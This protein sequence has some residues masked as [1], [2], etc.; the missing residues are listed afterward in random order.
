MNKIKILIAVVGCTLL[1]NHYAFSQVWVSVDSGW[2]APL[3]YFNVDTLHN[4]LYGTNGYIFTAGGSSP[5]RGCA[6]YDGVK[7]DTIPVLNNYGSALGIQY[8]NKFIFRQGSLFS[9]DGG[10]QVDT[11]AK[12]SLGGGASGL[13]THNGILYAYGEFDSINGIEAHDIAKWDGTTWS[14]IDT[15][16]WYSSGI[17]CATFYNNELYIGGGMTNFGNTI[18]QV[19][20]W[21]GVHWI[22]L[23]NGVRG[24]FTDVY[25]CEVYN[26]ELY[27]GGWFD[28]AGGNPGNA[29]ARWNG[30][31]WN[32]VGGGMAHTNSVIYD[33]QV[34]NNELFA[35]GG[36]LEAGG[37]T[38]SLIGKWDGSNWCSVGFNSEAASSLRV[39]A[40]Y[41]NELYI[42]GSFI[43]INGDTMHNVAKWN[44]GN[45]VGNCGSTAGVNEIDPQEEISIYPNPSNGLFTISATG[46]KIKEVRVMDVMGRLVNSEELK[47]NSTSATIDM[48]GYAKGVYFV[49]VQTENGIINKKV[50]IQ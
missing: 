47:A 48:S 32:D 9:W 8:G 15:T 30:T 21:D 13:M 5:S 50:I 18:S 2:S 37:I 34:F 43:T 20:K 25:C 44:G 12:F 40:V 41:N 42:G 17:Y 22:Q 36:F 1:C 23:G 24:G 16:K 7:W 28:F 46:T 27:F 10:T 29:I 39:M 3:I 19:A 14:A 33:L 49:R 31:Q 38:D 4:K 11:L 6:Q 26:N 45:Y 35:C